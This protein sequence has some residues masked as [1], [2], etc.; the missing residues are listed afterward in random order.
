MLSALLAATDLETSET[1]VELSPF[2]VT[3]II[4]TLLPIATGL[5]TKLNASDK[6][7]G[8]VNLFLAAVT[9]IISQN[10]VEGGGAIFSEDTL[11]M[12]L[13]AFIASVA[14]Y[15]GFWQNINIDEKLAP[16]TGIGG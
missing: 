4:G 10:L 11:L 16:N 14:A 9:A 7:K 2:L 12:G 13:L 1:S 3:L 5:L 15:H 6:V 8:T